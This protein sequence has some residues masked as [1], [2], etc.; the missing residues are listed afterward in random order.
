MAD[1]SHHD[2]RAPEG[3]VDSELDIKTIVRFGVG[4]V[5]VTLVVLAV[6]WWMSAAFKRQEEA[7]DRPLSPI[8]EAR[9]ETIPAGPRLQ[10]SP[11]RDLSEMRAE[12]KEVLT[13]YGWVDQANG[14]ARIPV[15]RAMSILVE[16]SRTAP[17]DKKKETR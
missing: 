14:I 8:P 13:T 5:V 1:H 2:S 9:V 11:P 7:K 3:G 12:D 17:G 16:R 15:E 4:L 6:M 10:P